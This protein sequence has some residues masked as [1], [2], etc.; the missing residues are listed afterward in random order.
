VDQQ[1]ETNNQTGAKQGPTHL[2]WKRHGTSIYFADVAGGFDVR[3]CPDPENLAAFIHTACNSHESLSAENARLRKALEL[4]DI[5][6]GSLLAPYSPA[7]I[8]EQ[9]TLKRCNKDHDKVRAAIKSVTP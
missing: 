9:P 1:P 5:T 7:E 4:A 8:A 6:I 2:P 3:N